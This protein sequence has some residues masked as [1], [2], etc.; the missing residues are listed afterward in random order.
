MA[1]KGC[2]ISDFIENLLK[3]KNAD[4]T[5]K[6]TDA[7]IRGKLRVAFKG[8]LINKAQ[9][10][11][12]T[13]KTDLL[14]TEP[15]FVELENLATKVAN[16]NKS[17]FEVLSQD[18]IKR[19]VELSNKAK[20]SIGPGASGR[21]SQSR[22]ASVLDTLNET[23]PTKTTSILD[24]L[25]R[26]I[27]KAELVG[28]LARVDKLR[29]IKTSFIDMSD[30]SS[31]L[32]IDWKAIAKTNSELDKLTLEYAMVKEIL[33]IGDR[34]T[35]EFKKKFAVEMLDIKNEIEKTQKRTDLT[36]DEKKK[37][38]DKLIIKQQELLKKFNE[39]TSK[40]FKDA[41][42]KLEK[43]LKTI[44]YQIQRLKDN[45]P[46]SFLN[47]ILI[48]ITGIDSE[49]FVT[50]LRELKER[51][52]KTEDDIKL[53]EKIVEEYAE[54]KTFTVAE[55]QWLFGEDYTSTKAVKEAFYEIE[56]NPDGSP[57]KDSTNKPIK[58]RKETIT[59][60]DVKELLKLWSDFKR[61]KSYESTVSTLEST[62][63]NNIILAGDDKLVSEI[64]PE[65]PLPIARTHTEAKTAK[66]GY[67]YDPR[68]V[69]DRVKGVKDLQTALQ[70]LTYL[71][72]LPNHKG[73]IS[74]GMLVGVLGQDAQSLFHRFDDAVMDDLELDNPDQAE[75]ETTM[76]GRRLVLQANLEK[77]GFTS[78]E[79]LA[80]P[81]FTDA[82]YV[83]NFTKVVAFD[84]EWEPNTN[85]IIAVGIV[86]YING[87]P[88]PANTEVI[89]S[90][91]GK[92]QYLTKDDADEV[93]QRLHTYQNN[94]FKVVGHNSLGADSDMQ[95]L[96]SVSGNT[97]L[98]MAVAMRSLDTML[99]GFRN[100]PMGTF[101]RSYGPSLDNLSKALGT[102]SKASKA[103]VTG[104]TAHEA[105]KASHASGDYTDFTDYLIQDVALTGR[106]LLEM[107]HRKNTTVD[108]NNARGEPQPVQLF[109]IT[110]IW[111]DTGKP[112]IGRNQ[113]Y[114]GMNVLFDIVSFKNM[115]EQMGLGLAQDVMY[116]V[117]KLKNIT[118]QMILA[119][120]KAD[121]KT[122]IDT[123][124]AALNAREETL[125][126][127]FDTLLEISR[128]NHTAYLPILREIRK[129][130]RN[131]FLL[132]AS[133]VSGSE[134]VYS[135]TP[136]K[137]V[138]ETNALEEVIST[139]AAYNRNPQ[140]SLDKFARLVGF[141]ERNEGESALSYLRELFNYSATKF[142]N[143]NLTISD[144]GDGTFDYVPAKQLGR[145]FAQLVLGHI[146]DGLKLS[147][148]IK[149][150]VDVIDQRREEAELDGDKIEFE[151]ID[152]LV[153]K[154]EY[155]PL[156][157]QN[158]SYFAPLS[159]F[160]QERMYN[161]FALRQ[162]YHY[163][164]NH[165]LTDDDLRQFADW[166]KVNPVVELKNDIKL[167]Q[168]IIKELRDK[169]LKTEADLA[170]LEKVYFPSGMTFVTPFDDYFL[171]DKSISFEDKIKQAKLLLA[172]ANQ[173]LKT[174]FEG[175]D[176]GRLEQGRV[177]RYNLHLVPN[178]RSI[179]TR[180]PT[181]EEMEEMSL[182][183][184]LDL[185]QFI[186]TFVHD[187]VNLMDSANV[188]VAGENHWEMPELS[189]GGPTGAA[190][191]AGIDAQLAWLMSH[192]ELGRDPEL[193]KE[194]TRKSLENG[195]KQFTSR[196]WSRTSYWDDH[197]SGIHHKAAM[198]W[199]YFPDSTFKAQGGLLAILQGIK[200]GAVSKEKLKDYYVETYSQLEIALD[201]V[202]QDF[203]N[204]GLTENVK[205]I[206]KIRTLLNGSTEV[207]EFFKGVI[208]PVVYEG[209][210]DAALEGL[211]DKQ[212]SKIS[213][214]D[215]IH[216]LSDEDLKEITR[217]LTETGIVVQGRLVD[218]ILGLDTNKVRELMKL[219]EQG[220]ERLAP[221][222]KVATDAMFKRN[223]ILKDNFIHLDGVREG[224]KIRL[225]TI[226]EYTMPAYLENEP[227][228]K[229]EEWI[230]RRI[231]FLENKWQTRINVALDIVKKNGGFLKVGSQA[232]RDFH[233]ALAGDQAA[234]KTQ[235]TLLG[236]NK[237]QN[238]GIKLNSSDRD[239]L[240]ASVMTGRHIADSDLMFT[241]HVVFTTVGIGT[242]SGRAQ[243]VGNYLTNLHGSRLSKGNRYVENPDGSIN[244]KE[245]VQ[246]SAWSL[247][248]ND[249]TGLPRDV[250][251]KKLRELAVKNYLLTVATDYPPTMIGYNMEDES[252]GQFFKEWQKRSR[253]ERE[254]EANERLTD[255]EKL[256]AAYTAEGRT[257]TDEQI[258]QAIASNST[259]RNKRLG[260]RIL[261]PTITTNDDDAVMSVEDAKGLAGFRPRLADNAFED[262]I[263]H[264]LYS[265]Y[266]GIK[267]LNLGTEK[268]RENLERIEKEGMTPDKVFDMEN[269]R[270]TQYDPNKLGV[271]FPEVESSLVESIFGER[272][273]FNQRVLR[274][275]YVLDTF[276]RRN[277]LQDLVDNKEYATIYQIYKIRQSL[278]KFSFL[279]SQK[280]MQPYELRYLHRHMV[281]Q[282]FRLTKAQR[283]A[284]NAKRNILDLSK[285]IGIDPEH[286]RYPDNTNMRWIDVLRTLADLGIEEVSTIRFGMSPVEMLTTETGA[287][288]D[289]IA[290]RKTAIFPNTI[291]GGDVAVIFERIWA[292]DLVQKEA[293]A[294]LD[295]LVKTGVITGYKTDQTNKYVLLSSLDKATEQQV[296]EHVLNNDELIMGAAENLGLFVDF[297]M[298]TSENILRLQNSQ[299]HANT[300][301]V[302]INPQR[303]LGE[304]TVSRVVEG[305]Q[306]IKFYL[307]PEAVKRI[308]RGARNSGL[309]TRIETAVQI[310]K[311]LGTSTT[312]DQLRREK[313]A[314]YLDSHLDQLAD[315]TDILAELQGDSLQRL[316]TDR[317][318]DSMGI[319]LNLYDA[320][321][322]FHNEDSIT[323]L[324]PFKNAVTLDI[325]IAAERASR[326]P[327]LQTEYG[328]LDRLMTEDKNKWWFL[329]IGFAIFLQNNLGRT[330]T[331]QELRVILEEHF[332]E[333]FTDV[334]YN[335]FTTKLA[336]VTNIID[337]INH[338]PFKGKN[339]YLHLAIK[340]REQMLAV[341]QTFNDKFDISSFIKNFGVPVEDHDIAAQ[342]VIEAYA[343]VENKA[344]LPEAYSTI[345]SNDLIKIASSSTD[346][347]IAFPEG[348]QINA[349]LVK[350]KMDGVIDDET[351]TFYRLLIG[352]VLKHNPHLAKFLSIKVDDLGTIR[353]GEAVKDGDR[354]IINLN[355][356]ILKNMGRV[357]QIRVFSHEIAHIARLA[358]IKDNGS[359][360]RRIESL[361]KSKKGSQAIETM[362]LAMNN[363]QRYEGFEQD[364]RYYKDNPEEFIAV[365]GGW[366]LVEQ[367]FNNV[368]V[369][370]FIQSR[371]TT[372]HAVTM[373]YKTAFHRIRDEV[374]AI[375]SGLYDIDEQ[376]FLEVMDLT[377]A[378]FGFTSSVERE[379][380]VANENKT[381]GYLGDFD[382]PISNTGKDVDEL[383]RLT[384]DERNGVPLSALDQLKLASLRNKYSSGPI[385][386]LDIVE[387]RR[388]RQERE[389]LQGSSLL[390]PTH[391][392]H[393]GYT[394][395][396]VQDLSPA[397][398]LEIAQTVVSETIARRKNTSINQSSLGGS[399]RHAS[400]KVF[401]KKAT[402]N[403]L[404]FRYHW[405]TMGLTQANKTYQSENPVVAALMY[406][407]GESFSHTQGQ[408]V[409]ETGSRAI[410]ENRAY[411][412]QWVERVAYE[413]GQLKIM[414]SD[415]EF[416]ALMEYATDVAYG[417]PTA[418][419]PTGISVDKI[420]QARE[421][422]KAIV[423]N[424]DNMAGF[425]YGEGRNLFGKLPVML[426][427][428]LLG[429]R[430][431]NANPDKEAEFETNRAGL[432]QAASDAVVDS[433]LNKGAINGTLF[434][435]SG[436]APQISGHPYSFDRNQ[437]IDQ[438]FLSKL[439]EAKNNSPETFEIIFEIAVRQL[440]KITK[441]VARSRQML[442]QTMTNPSFTFNG[443]PNFHRIWESA[444][445]TFYTYVNN[446]RNRN[447]LIK[448]INKL[449]KTDKIPDVDLTV[450]Q[451]F[452]NAIDAAIVSKQPIRNM[453]DLFVEST[454]G[455]FPPGVTNIPAGKK[456]AIVLTAQTKT[457]LPEIVAGV[458]L[459]EL[460]ESPNFILADGIITDAQISKSAN[461]R[462]YFSNRFDAMLSDVER[463]KG[464][465]ATSALAIQDNTGIVGFDIYDLL[466]I[467]ES[468]ASNMDPNLSQ[469]SKELQESLIVIRQKLEIEQG[470]QARKLGE[471]DD[472]YT[473]S[474][475]KWGPEITRIAYGPN[476]N[477]ASLIM[478]GALGAFIT[479]RYG[480]KAT[481]F[482]TDIFTGIFRN[483]KGSF[484]DMTTYN[485]RGIAINMMYGIESSV[486][487]AREV[488][489]ITNSND[490]APGPNKWQRYRNH[491]SKLQN[492]VFRGTAEALTNQ[493]QRIIVENL[494]NGNLN[495]L[496]TLFKVEDIRT[497]DDLKIAMNKYKIKGLLPHMAFEL[498]Q[499]GVLEDGILE[500]YSYMLANVSSKHAKAGTLDFV[501][502]NKWIENHAFTVT[503]VGKNKFNKE[504]AMRSVAVMYEAT[505]MF[506]NI[507]LVENNPWDSD[508]HSGVLRFL[509]TFYKQY[510]NLYWSQR[511]MRQSGKMDKG[512]FVSVLIGTTIADLVYNSFLLVALGMIPLTALLPWHEQFL[513]KNKPMTTARLILSRNPIFGLT[514]NLA[515]GAA[516]YAYETYS[517]VSNSRANRNQ[518]LATKKAVGKGFDELS[519]D[520]VPQQAVETLTKDPLT[521]FLVALS[522]G[523]NMTEQESWDFK[524][525]LL[526]SAMRLVPGG[527]GEL[528]V[529]VAATK[530]ALGERPGVDRF[531]DVNISRPE[532]TTTESVAPSESPRSTS[533]RDNPF[534]PLPVPKGL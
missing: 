404:A 144:F 197:M 71:S 467:F 463:S 242:G 116:D 165:D 519:L 466:E 422:A 387:Y 204:A 299:F 352:K 136:T 182:E 258:E 141:R 9:L 72:S 276:A 139:L 403:L 115:Q 35:A 503:F 65:D 54:D 10:I 202:E 195:W 356:T 113:R 79:I 108:V 225:R 440:T 64:E 532:T 288:P 427:R 17:I 396:S 146:D 526:N 60:A 393:P 227:R 162:R 68:K 145:G 133:R 283:D 449:G 234:F 178:N 170:R 15:E 469:N 506:R 149:T 110:P 383:A 282:I 67:Q 505:K 419:P 105:W 523:S 465:R 459:S 201:K 199:S 306:N 171:F 156:T 424:S 90:R 370:K 355:P 527:L 16:S 30:L 75:S 260:T 391:R 210:Y 214:G 135:R 237:M 29:K 127:N 372:A 480:G 130:N 521:A 494:N 375:S 389:S 484:E 18:Q 4:G 5:R 421:V 88:V 284:T 492:S 436:L 235:M 388:L 73:Y 41:R 184:A 495:K 479:A 280:V 222:L 164:L 238:S 285:S 477:T 514:G 37:I 231:A 172:E 83:D 472:W 380:F 259:P 80:M 49:F 358:F 312:V 159:M 245:T 193:L 303:G 294:Y 323:E 95:K 293:K 338:S 91:S 209:G 405:G 93:L 46:N 318:K 251:K 233:V 374:K 168:A 340:H 428:E 511:I 410:R 287:A 491:M 334:T 485:P 267:K 216:Q 77:L 153:E 416:T 252:R 454:R 289:I 493:A 302:Y 444:T 263:V 191:L 443:A 435:A 515:I 446:T 47:K 200:D 278:K 439:W 102:G 12:T 307:T 224:I 219:F 148:N 357:D 126:Q 407:I 279:V 460:G 452:F 220:V 181:M 348:K 445:R 137:S 236:I 430:K 411:T 21:L 230:N 20:N 13:G 103:G 339:K 257:L 2:N 522:A 123:I 381:L 328:V 24:V 528:P 261:A 8:G 187:S 311:F 254:W 386:N 525:G 138:Y 69:A 142:N 213:P 61:S 509:F 500:A 501:A 221:N 74:T 247:A 53:A 78:S 333:K 270:A 131:E 324:T 82:G 483:Y 350:L 163:I 360:W 189:S 301:G 192:P 394:G 441:D 174:Y 211:R 81:E 315:E 203:A 109:D 101:T 122:D 471:E 128:S 415:T 256:K 206:Q 409:K 502:A 442:K 305:S 158:V 330:L 417:L 402:R 378:L 366:M 371:S 63:I 84:I 269:S 474:L 313:Y 6:F 52:L 32:K 367:V 180:I 160:E 166:R 1:T 457:S 496:R 19:V 154:R 344:N 155:L 119:L 473:N 398:R 194:L 326:Y 292:N 499:A 143:Q 319:E 296:L 57:K 286:F 186:A 359:E 3:E 94:G 395:V 14:I 320:E 132:D 530:L 498:K 177:Q 11:A 401:G 384:Q 39:T 317:L 337:R 432:I 152:N 429:L 377:E 329:R 400:E 38:I 117:A 40:K 36:D 347:D 23:P 513:F 85:N 434:Y 26:S 345:P 309:F 346:F 147:Q 50:S 316:R 228:V 240:E 134:V 70:R 433:V 363:N 369:M 399:A 107:V 51:Q 223:P 408:F 390:K 291:Q 277:G 161:D 262:R 308:L 425:I 487:N 482:F 28:D 531:K 476:L 104:V 185:P 362:L 524:N 249:L 335:E 253:K 533:P 353:A 281:Q 42:R 516:A 458:F 504:Q 453:G 426:N 226:A 385:Q 86:E 175:L 354:F 176:K 264:G 343:I 217:I 529:R 125:I 379:I 66:V 462:K 298:G 243:Y 241:D 106:N 431:K 33:D 48:S 341:P 497:L 239:I 508:T 111:Y 272:P 451:N 361:F 455:S 55:V 365:W 92:D 179:Y 310:N 418:T 27:E 297:E 382:E 336:Q 456:S 300:D 248:G 140:R 413:I 25:D 196:G 62:R 124:F 87:N 517:D 22:L 232:E 373:G 169:T 151:D 290:G 512:T 321:Y 218:E 114:R 438:E 376:V 112:E 208:I 507:V 121:N 167:K 190:R 461:L 255:I 478:E 229:Q 486:R 314:E 34:E 188:V 273:T 490:I 447:E 327:A 97:N 250:A 450:V 215:P 45:A 244:W 100:S 520:F 7:Q 120:M 470:I 265:I 271:Y 464:F 397:Q 304:I 331:E 332:G 98:G 58:K 368:D 364:L 392:N 468:L 43:K 59:L 488:W 56:K 342:A 322:Y 414:S 183:I 207:R 510:S 481:E 489:D 212:K 89:W 266:Q 246:N 412:Q 129:A 76:E 534:K 31:R 99:L 295:N 173:N 268:V 448:S 205:Q 349:Q 96:V 420:D 275:K 406:I 150:P 157:K 274:L 423:I 475:L 325:R 44:N 518:Y 118:V 198:L 351:E 437:F